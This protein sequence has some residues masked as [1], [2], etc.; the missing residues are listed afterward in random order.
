[1][2]DHVDGGRYAGG[3]V[4]SGGHYGPAK[5]SVTFIDNS[6]VTIAAR[7]SPHRSSLVNATLCLCLFF[8]LVLEQSTAHSSGLSAFVNECYKENLQ[9]N[10][11]VNNYVLIKPFKMPELF[12]CKTF[13]I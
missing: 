3:A 1:M 5:W 7:S 9:I 2:K 4:W 6:C 8:F 13:N 11:Q 12:I 10:P